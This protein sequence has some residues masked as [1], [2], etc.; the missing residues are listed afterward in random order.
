MVVTLQNATSVVERFIVRQNIQRYNVLNALNVT[1][2]RDS[3]PLSC[4]RRQIAPLR[5]ERGWKRKVARIADDNEPHTM[6]LRRSIIGIKARVLAAGDL[7][8]L[9][10]R[11]KTLLLVL[12]VSEVHASDAQV[13]SW[14]ANLL[15]TN[16]PPRRT[17]STASSSS[18]P[19]SILTT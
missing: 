7:H 9:L 11:C 6:I 16:C 3:K 2:Q 15:P 1:G 12:T 4:F 18:L 5:S 14:P 19:A 8:A 10:K 13:K 17:V